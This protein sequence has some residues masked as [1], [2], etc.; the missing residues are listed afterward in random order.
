MNT[1]LLQINIK[2]TFYLIQDLS[3]VSPP[4][5]FLLYINI[6]IYLYIHVNYLDT[7]YL[8]IIF[9]AVLNLYFFDSS[10]PPFFFLASN[11]FSSNKF[12][13][14]TVTYLYYLYFSLNIW[15]TSIYLQVEN[16]NI[17]IS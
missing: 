1:T 8:N 7:L 12:E 3:F 16:I 15:L 6:Y 9:F 2:K 13:F 4:F 5:S 17:R 10:P 14:K 11:I